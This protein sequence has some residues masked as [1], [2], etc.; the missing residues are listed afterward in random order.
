MEFDLFLTVMNVCRRLWK[1]NMRRL[2]IALLFLIMSVPGCNDQQL[3]Y[4]ARQMP[5]D[6]ASDR[7]GMRWAAET[8]LSKCAYC[9][10]HESEGRGP[11]A[12]FFEPPAPDF[13][14]S[15]YRSAEPAYLY[16]RIAEGKTVEPFLS[17]GS[18][19]PAWGAHFSEREIWLLTAFLQ[20]RAMPQ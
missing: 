2:F 16:W 1:M 17:R 4:P 10:G 18:V 5:A 7:E 6:I 12:D 13:S 8:F 20:Q 19:M 15:K 3:N 14:E 11:R 9:H